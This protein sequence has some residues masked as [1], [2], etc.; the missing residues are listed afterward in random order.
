MP[1]GAACPFLALGLALVTAGPALA[2]CSVDAEPVAFGTIDVTRPS[3]GTGT[4]LVRCD[5][6]ASFEVGISTDGGSS[7]RM[8]GPGGARLDYQLYT[9]ASRSTP[10]SDGEAGGALRRGS[11]DGNGPT[12]LTIYGVVPA[13]PG[14]APGEYRDSL[15]VTL[16]F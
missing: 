7:R 3:T 12:R 10:W 6:E 15:A 4:I 11:N 14:T 16:M 8:E 13:Q 9:D 1:L 2:A 5:A